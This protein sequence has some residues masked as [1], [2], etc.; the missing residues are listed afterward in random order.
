VELKT[1]HKDWL[2]ARGIDPVLA[3]K[4]GLHTVQ[5]EGRNWLAVPY[6]EHGRTV[7]HKYRVTS[8]KS[9]QRMDQ[10]APLT[11]LNHDCLL[12]E[13]LASTPLII[14]E[15]EFDLLAC[16]TVGKRRVVSV[17]NGAPKQ[18]SDDQ[19]LTEGARYAWFWR[20]QA[21][22][23]RVKQVIIAVDGDEAGK[24]LAA[25]LCRL[26]GPER[27]MFVEWSADCKDANDVL[28]VHG[29]EALVAVLDEAKP[30][31]VKGLYAIDDFPEQPQY[32][33]FPSGITEFDDLF[34]V[35]PR[36]FTVITGYAGQGKTSF[37]MWIISLLIRRGVHV[38]VA[39]FETDIK[40][41]F[42]RKLRAAILGAG[43]FSHH[44]P[45]DLAWADQMIRRHL[46]IISHSPADDDDSLSIEDV[47]ELGRASVIRNGT[48]VLLIDPWN[49]VEHKRGKEES[50][51][52][53]TG[54]AIR[55]VKR[56]AKQND[57]ATIVIAHPSKPQ[58]GAGPKKLAGLYDISGSA[59]WANKADYGLT[60]RIKNRD[61]WTSTVA[62]TKVRMGLPGRVGEITLQFDR[63]KSS[64]S[65]YA[66]DAEQAA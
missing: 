41:I 8:E 38:T 39:S 40:P 5:M 26:F 27:C 32:T 66:F 51:T 56:F 54:R 20:H 10:G 11:L 49:E 63:N 9:A 57:V 13:S 22:L 17:P 50:E 62:V 53:Y 60:F 19:E 37:L 6:V 28:Q 23:D 33:A 12:D 65:Y 45:K 3:E 52:D 15:G 35:V 47:L 30:Y 64:Y 31:P 58:M 24:A 18:S 25:D 1:P 14:V 43:E 48:R 36:T 29:A 42:V 46:A 7:N 21:Q 34:Q 44:D 59:N 4:F 16:M 61:F 55:A 2:G